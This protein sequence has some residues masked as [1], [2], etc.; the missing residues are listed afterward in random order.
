MEEF[1]FYLSK[2][3]EIGYI[4]SFFHS[5]VF[6]SGLPGLQPKEVV[7]TESGKKG[8]V[9][10]L[11]KEI[12][13]VL[14]FGGEVKVGERVARTGEILKIPV[15]EGL[16]GRIVDPLMKPL[17]GLG[18]ISG[19]KFL[20]EIE[21]EAPPIKERRRIERFFETG[22][23]IV[24]LLIPLGFGQRE[25]VIGD[26]KTGKTTFLVQTIVSQAKQGTIPIYVGIAKKDTALKW[27]Q[28]YL[29]RQRVFE[30]T[31]L[32][33]TTPDD[34]IAL[35]YLAPFSGM[36][37][38]E[39]FRDK[40]N[41]VLIIFDDLSTH[42]KIYRQ[43][44]LLLKRTPGRECYPGDIF[45]LHAALLERAGNLIKNKKEVSITALPVA[46]TLE[47][48]ISGYIPTNL[49][50]MTDGHIFFDIV[51]FRKGKRPAINAFLSVTRVGNQTKTKVEREIANWIKKVL[52]DCKRLEE[53]VKLGAELSL[54]NQKKIE[55]GRKLEILFNQSQDKILER[56]TQ[57][58][59][60]GLLISG[61][62]DEKPLEKMKEEVE[63][64]YFAQEKGILPKI[65]E[66]IDKIKDLTH[67]NF[68][69]KE[70]LPMI[71]KIFKI[72]K[73]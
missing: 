73:C 13:Q 70:I 18:P 50:A 26:A 68:L 57:L 39:Y 61:F 35:I 60:I 43:I 58:I 19:E 30:R 41:D 29:Q 14:L 64:I 17:D 6:V 69:L 56:N 63:K 10:G 51:E 15:S 27:V 5:L 67:L 25:L 46:E 31:I 28:E 40:G 24:D 53:F 34:P 3:K 44:S 12:S 11:K 65:P 72:V 16:F 2:T 38:A 37:L 1:E 7:I 49:M 36:A 59:L 23:M 9:I 32:I 54:E 20:K 33:H 47:N 22:V 52:L 71:E 21:R 4:E 62:W 55:L 66:E 45:H 8:M 42:A 48:D